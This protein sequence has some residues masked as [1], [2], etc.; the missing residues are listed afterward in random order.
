MVAQGGE[1]GAHVYEAIKKFNTLLL[2]IASRIYI[3]YGRWRPKTS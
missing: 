1:K 3:S 2:Q